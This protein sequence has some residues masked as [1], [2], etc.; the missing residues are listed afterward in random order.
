MI[1]HR[2]QGKPLAPLVN[3]TSTMDLIVKFSGNS[4]HGLG[5]Y[6]LPVHPA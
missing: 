4:I 6:H 2:P 1:T 5:R 3:V